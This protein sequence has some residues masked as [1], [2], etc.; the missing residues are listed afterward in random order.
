MLAK[1]AFKRGD[2]LYHSVHGLCCVK[3]IVKQN[4]IGKEEGYYSLV[5]KLTNRMGIRFLVSVNDVET[6]GFHLPISLKEANE[7]LDYLKTSN[8]KASP[9]SLV[10]DNG[11]W[12]FAK[13]VLVFS[14]DKLQD[15][16]QRKR[17]LLDRAAKGLVRELAFVLEISAKQ[18][19]S[20]VQRSLEYASSVNP[21]VLAI[22]KHI[23]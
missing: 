5:P 18:A 6:S 8:V 21:S 12:A 17:E 15:R 3:E 16:N 9:D 14:C 1:T 10:Q 20:K 11:A 2:A 19:A 22:L 13:A 23:N 4:G 7:I